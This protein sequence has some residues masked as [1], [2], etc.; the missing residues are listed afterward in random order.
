MTLKNNIEKILTQLIPQINFDNY[1]NKDGSYWSVLQVLFNKIDC[2]I[3]DINEL[4]P[5][6]DTSDL[7]MIKNLLSDLSELKDLEV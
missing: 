4:L 3:L 5:E 6:Y 1:Q 2:V 7:E